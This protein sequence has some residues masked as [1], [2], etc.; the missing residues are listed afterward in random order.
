MKWHYYVTPQDLRMQDSSTLHRYDP[1]TLVP[2]QTWSSE[3]KEWKSGVFLEY[4]PTNPAIRISLKEAKQIYGKYPFT[5][6]YKQ[7]TFS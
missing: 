6:R 2:R 5:K 1:K 7:I 4:I 3:F